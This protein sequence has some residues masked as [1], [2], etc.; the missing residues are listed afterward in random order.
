MTLTM[1][2]EE[3]KKNLHK[4]MAPGTYKIADVLCEDS[5]YVVRENTTGRHGAKV[6]Q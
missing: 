4:T 1:T 6:H 2:V 3:V 5:G